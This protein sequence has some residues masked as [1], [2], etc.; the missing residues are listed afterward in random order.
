MF[1]ILILKGYEEGGLVAKVN[2]KTTEF[3]TLT[4][5]QD[6]RVLVGTDIPGPEIPGTN[7]NDYAVW[8]NA[9]TGRELARSPLL[10]VMTQGAMIQPFYAGDMFFE[11]Q[12]GTLIKLFPTSSPQT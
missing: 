8:R 12:S 10:P 7:M 9:A 2:Q 6:V 1:Q 3:T 11:G 5:P 4:G